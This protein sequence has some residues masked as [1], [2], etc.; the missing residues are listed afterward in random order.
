MLDVI[1]FYLRK[2]FSYTSSTPEDTEDDG[3]ARSIDLGPL[4]FSSF[5]S[6]VFFNYTRKDIQEC[7]ANAFWSGNVNYF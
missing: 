7:N 2:I 4:S 1:K 3:L 5:Y 6:K